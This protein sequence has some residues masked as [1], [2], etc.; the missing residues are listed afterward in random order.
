[1]VGEYGPWI[2]QLDSEVSMDQDKYG[3][4]DGLNEI[5]RGEATTTAN[6]SIYA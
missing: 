3:Q 6:R 2:A 4:S 1:M 5:S